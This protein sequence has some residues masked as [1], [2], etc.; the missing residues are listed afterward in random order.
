M[1]I[2]DGKS[3][4]SVTF[5]FYHVL[6]VTDGIHSAKLLEPFA[7]SEH[8]PGS[9]IVVEY[10][11]RYRMQT[12]IGPSKPLKHPSRNLIEIAIQKFVLRPKRV[13]NKTLRQNGSGTKCK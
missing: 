6:N 1:L 12:F 10:S 9:L 8:P 13:L 7:V 2:W 11:H 3:R 5:A 4:I